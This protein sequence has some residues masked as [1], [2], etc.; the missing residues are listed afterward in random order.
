MLVQPVAVLLCHSVL[1]TTSPPVAV[2][3]TVYHTVTAIAGSKASPRDL[4]ADTAFA[5]T[6]KPAERSRPRAS[7]SDLL[8]AELMASLAS[9]TGIHSAQALQQLLHVEPVDY[10]AMLNGLTDSGCSYVDVIADYLHNIRAMQQESLEQEAGSAAFA[11]SLLKELADSYKQLVSNRGQHKDT[12][13]DTLMELLA[14]NTKGGVQQ[15]AAAVV[16]APAEPQLQK[17]AVVDSLQSQLQ[18]LIA[19]LAASSTGIATATAT[20]SDAA[21]AVAPLPL[22]PAPPAVV[23]APA[24][25]APAPTAVASNAA[26]ADGTVSMSASS[27][28]AAIAAA[29]Q[30]LVQQ[31]ASQQQQPQQQQPPQAWQQQPPVATQANNL[32]QAQ[33]PQKIEL[34]LHALQMLLQMQ[35]SSAQTAAAAA[36]AQPPAAVAAD[37]AHMVQAIHAALQGQLSALSAAGSNSAAQPTP[38]VNYS[39]PGLTYNLPP[40]SF[41]LAASNLSASSAAMMQPQPAMQQQQPPGMQAQQHARPG[42]DNLQRVPSSLGLAMYT[43]EWG[44]PN[45]DASSAAGTGASGAPLSSSSSL[46]APAATASSGLSSMPSMASSALELFSVPQPP[47]QQQQQQGGSSG[48]DVFGSCQQQQ[49]QLPA[50]A[51]ASAGPPGLMQ[52]GFYAAAGGEMGANLATTLSGNLGGNYPLGA[53]GMVGAGGGGIAAGQGMHLSHLSMDSGATAA[54]QQHQQQQQMTAQL[55]SLGA[56]DAANLM[57]M[58][59]NTG[60]GGGGGANVIGVPSSAPMQQGYGAYMPEH[61]MQWWAG[62]Q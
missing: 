48:L 56:A 47:Q 6:S 32:P 15:P 46:L 40:V 57:M 9:K 50:G 8:A 25:V 24:V 16:E 18:E 35:P 1:C 51:A 27:L 19:A 34:D 58:Y 13:K 4:V 11:D 45:S 38:L 7:S 55:A 39:T 59:G 5:A 28:A 22:V 10:Q 49:Q 31:Q 42:Q 33:Q 14:A 17:P 36:N 37:P 62:P 43:A 20:A 3:L 29:A 54:Q 30:L 2:K 23:Q 21:V 41:G 52:P 60:G 26:Q 44:V 61:T 12:V 53:D